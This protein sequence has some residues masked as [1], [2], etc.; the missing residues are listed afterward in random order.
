M[1]RSTGWRKFAIVTTTICGIGLVALAQAPK[2]PNEQERQIKEAEVPAAALATLKKLAGASDI[3]GFSEEI[4]H[5]HTYYEGS[6]KGAG[7]K[8]DALV[9]ADG[10]LVEIEESISQNALPKPVLE[11]V[12]TIAGDDAKLYVEKKTVVFYEIKFKKDNRRHA[13]VF[14]PDGRQHEHEQENA[15]EGEDD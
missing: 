7:G 3:T 12:R 9:T 4:E 6:W 13:I 10:D 2:E 8:L 15:A 14:S 1:D 11:N 5:G